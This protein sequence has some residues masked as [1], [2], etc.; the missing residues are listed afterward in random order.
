[1]INQDYLLAENNKLWH[2]AM[3]RLSNCNPVQE[4]DIFRFIDILN[5]ERDKLLGGQY[6]IQI[7]KANEGRIRRIFGN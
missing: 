6:A 7:K 3:N 2:E 4:P 1:M 5:I